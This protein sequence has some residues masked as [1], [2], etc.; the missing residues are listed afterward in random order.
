MAPRRRARRLRT[1]ASHGEGP[2][3]GYQ[4]VL[5]AGTHC[6]CRLATSSHALLRGQLP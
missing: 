3:C 5:P 2:A 1:E 4:L 6:S